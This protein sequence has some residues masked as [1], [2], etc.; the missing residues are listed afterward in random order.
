MSKLKK[1][2]KSKSKEQIIEEISA[3]IIQALEDGKRVWSMPFM[4]TEGVH[5]AYN[6][7]S[8]TFYKGLMNQMSLG[9]RQL[10]EG[11]EH[12]AWLTY[13][14]AKALGGYVPREAKGKG[15][16]VT[17]WKFTK[18]E[19]KDAEGNVIYDANGDAEM[20]KIPFLKSYKV[21]NVAQCKDIPMPEKKKEEKFKPLKVLK[22]AEAI[23]KKYDLQEKNLEIKIGDN[24]RACFI[25]SRD[26]IECPSMR[27]HVEVAKKNKQSVNDGK[28]HYY[29]TLFHEMI[30]SSGHK[31]RLDRLEENFSFGDHEY[32]KEELVAE[33]GSS[34]LCS[35]AG[36]NSEVVFDNTLAYCQSWA[37]KLKSD[38]QWILWASSRAL[39]ASNYILGGK[40]D[41]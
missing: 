8:K 18:I 14:G 26:V 17:F 6:Y 7:Q 10:K 2:F 33:I 13:K 23:V 19:K 31:S 21:F 22:D 32:S 15:A 24:M 39:T 30:H 40:N 9:C 28:Q 34:V 25:P 3:P 1:Q 29:S 37:K 27:N 5:S 36:L 11:W 16:I 12:N 41:K 38:P 4:R 20:R 35:E